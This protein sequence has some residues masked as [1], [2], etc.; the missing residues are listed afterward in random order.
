MKKPLHMDRSEKLFELAQK[1]LVGGVNSPVRAFK[2]VGGTP[3]FIQRGKGPFLIDVDGNRYLDLVGSWGPL[4]LGH[5]Q[6]DVVNAVKRALRKGFTFGAPSPLE[7]ELALWVKKAY[8]SIE[9]VRFVSSGTEAT[10]SAI[11]LARATTNK[12]RIVKFDG[13]YHG[14]GDSLL[15]AAG[16]GPA[17]LGLPDSPGVPEE[18]AALTL[19]VPYNDLGAV[20]SAFAKFNDIATVIVEPI[21]GN[22]GLVPPKAGFLQGLRE[23]TQKNG[24]ILIFDEVMT[25]FR[26]AFG[27]A[28]ELY[29][30]KPD[31]TTLGKILGGGMPVGAYGGREDLMNRVAPEGSVYQAGTLSGNPLAM[32]SGIATL[33]KLSDTKVYVALETSAAFVEEGIRRAIQKAGVKAVFQRVG[34]MATLFFTSAPVTNYDEAKNCDRGRYSEFFWAMARRGVY[35]PP[36]QFEAWFF[37]A[38]LSK[39]HLKKIVKSVEESLKEIA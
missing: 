12:K 34:S 13:C 6:T 28:Q 19:S 29:G 39:D 18:I 32:A 9:K 26:V 5:L 20:Q 22:M 8:P 23:I 10:F 11:R 30:V 24:A 15:V 16:S 33:K 27:G 36:S 3:L 14:H 17:T 37:S 25:G 4:I 31:L 2:G 7:T 38:A 35:L 21:A 1:H